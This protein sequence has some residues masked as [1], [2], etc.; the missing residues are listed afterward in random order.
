MAW[1]SHVWQG[2]SRQ[3]HSVPCTAP[4]I[5]SLPSSCAQQSWAGQLCSQ[6]LRKTSVFCAPQHHLASSVSA[7][8]R[9]NGRGDRNALKQSNQIRGVRTGRFGIFSLAIIPSLSPFLPSHHLL[10]RSVLDLLGWWGQLMSLQCPG[11][12][13]PS[14][15]PLC[16][17][18]AT[19][20]PQH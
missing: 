10:T 14:P 13:Q 17:L 5:P 12:D 19:P 2:R 18:S 15:D 4:L 7:T 3:E 9:T 11:Q 8:E 1:Q 20:L 16:L 6:C